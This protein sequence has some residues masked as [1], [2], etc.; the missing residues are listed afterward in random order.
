MFIEI[1]F[2]YLVIGLVN[3]IIAVPMYGYLG[4]LETGMDYLMCFCVYFFVWWYMW[5]DAL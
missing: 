2:W 4:R 3:A 5:W 1:I